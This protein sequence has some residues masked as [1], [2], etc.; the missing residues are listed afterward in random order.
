MAEWSIATDCKFVY[1]KVIIGSN[2]ILV[3][4]NFYFPRNLTVECLIDNRKI[5]V[6]FHSG[7]VSLIL[8]FAYNLMVKYAAHNGCYMGSNPVR[9]INERAIDSK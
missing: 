2:P 7:S 4:N 1:R 9:L 3:I 6:Q 8:K 5:M